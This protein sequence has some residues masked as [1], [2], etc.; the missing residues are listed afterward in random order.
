M[1]DLFQPGPMQPD[2]IEWLQ[3]QAIDSLDGY[4]YI[5]AWYKNPGLRQVTA[6]RWLGEAVAYLSIIDI[7]KAAK[8]ELK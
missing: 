2:P 4:H 7:L 3:R 1:N 5:N 6:K 8:G